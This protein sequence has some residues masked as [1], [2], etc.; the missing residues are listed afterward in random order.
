MLTLGALLLGGA[1]LALPQAALTF[2]SPSPP[3]WT[4][5]VWAEEVV[6]MLIVCA[7]IF[8]IGAVIA[9][10]YAAYSGQASVIDM[11]LAAVLVGL[12]VW[13]RRRLGLGARV[14]ALNAQETRTTVAPGGASAALATAG[15]AAMPQPHAPG[16]QAA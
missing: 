16:R 7:F 3:P 15:D 13:I 9:G 10:G 2:R 5:W 4:R 8:G 11:A 12:F 6:G 1:L 14:R